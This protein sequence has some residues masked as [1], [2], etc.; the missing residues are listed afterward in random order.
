MNTT[1]VLAFLRSAYGETGWPKPFNVL[2]GRLLV[3]GGAALG[4]AARRVATTTRAIEGI[5]NDPE[6]A[7]AVLRA[8]PADLE[9]VDVS[10]ARRRIAQVLIGRAAE[11]AFESIYKEEVGPDIEFTLEDKREDRNDTD[12]RVLNGRSRPVYRVNIKFFGANFRRGPEM[13]KLQP[14][15]CFPLAT[16]K[17][18]GA[19]QKQDQEHLPYIFIVVTVPDLTAALIERMVSSLDVEILAVIHK[20]TRVPRKREKED[21]VIDRIVASRSPAFVEVYDRIRAAGWYVLSARRADNLLK[22]KL[23]ER[24]YALRIPGFVHQFGRAEID[25]H[26]SLR[27]DLMPL[28]AFLDMLRDEGQTKIASLLE[29]GTA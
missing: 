12:Y 26:F 25:M 22:A 3:E 11:M 29:R 1:D 17:I 21:R 24:V 6:P 23:F 15:D 18:H 13:V 10:K 4:V 7:F 20:S 19:L 28:R 2:E 14:E 9:D 16:Y 8:S 5:L 27:E